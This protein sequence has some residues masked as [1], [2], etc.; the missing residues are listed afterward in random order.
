MKKK[1]VILV[2]YLFWFE[3]GRELRM[4]KLYN[5]D[6]AAKQLASNQRACIGNIYPSYELVYLYFHFTFKMA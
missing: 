4:Q 5:S 6:L 3:L 1:F 2:Q